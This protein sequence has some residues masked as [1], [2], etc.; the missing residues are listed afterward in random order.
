M[1]TIDGAKMSIQRRPPS[2][3][4]GLDPE[5]EPD[6]DQDDRRQQDREEPH[7]GLAEEQPGLDGVILV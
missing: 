7:P 5:Q 2:A 6:D 4:S 1:T 3:G